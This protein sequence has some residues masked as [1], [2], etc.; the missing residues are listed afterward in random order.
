[1]SE[2][3]YLAEQL[4]ARASVTPLDGGCQ[5]LIAERL[6]AIGFACETL[7]SGPDTFSVTNIWAKRLGTPVEIAQ[8]ASN[9][10]AKSQPLKTLVFAGHTDVVPTG[11]LAEWLSPPFTPSYRD[12]RLY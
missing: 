3:L 10:I 7:I 6:S 2:T 12:G 11:P 4:I 5:S 9:S 1:M 8:S